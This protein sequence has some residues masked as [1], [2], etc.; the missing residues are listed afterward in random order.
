MDAKTE[1][2]TNPVLKDVIQQS[3]EAARKNDAAIWG[4]VA[5]ALK[6]ATRQQ[7]EVNLSHLERNVDDGETVVV[8]G[9]VMG[10]GRL[11]KDVTVAALNF[12]NSAME[13]INDSGEAVYLEDLVEENPEGD[14]LRLLG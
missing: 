9:K 7:A 8:P 5:A 11:T 10:S 13:A 1:R 4:D 12:T 6:D 14:G 3:E 2:K